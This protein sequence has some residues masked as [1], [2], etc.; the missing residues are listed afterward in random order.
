MNLCNTVVL[1]LLQKIL[2]KEN[3]YR[4]IVSFLQ[5]RQFYMDGTSSEDSRIRKNVHHV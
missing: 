2:C 4:M 5:G 3:H 1:G